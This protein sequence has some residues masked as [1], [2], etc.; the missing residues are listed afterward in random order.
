MEGLIK[1]DLFIVPDPGVFTCGDCEI[2]LFGVIVVD[3]KEKIPGFTLFDEDRVGDKLGTY[4]GYILGLEAGVDPALK[5]IEMERRIAAV[6]SDGPL[7]P[8]RNK[9]NTA[10]H[11]YVSPAN[12]AEEQTDHD[13]E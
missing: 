10:F 6:N 3:L 8:S 13:K 7:L 2:T 9:R 1:N 12:E 11:P 5:S 4:V